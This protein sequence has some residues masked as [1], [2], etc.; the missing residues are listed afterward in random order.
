MQGLATNQV[1]FGAAYVQ[2]AIS[3]VK[4]KNE[5][6][7]NGKQVSIWDDYWLEGYRTLFN[8]TQ[9]QNLHVVNDLLDPDREG[10]NHKLLSQAFPCQIADKISNIECF[11]EAQSQH[12]KK[13]LKG[14]WLA[15]I[16]N[17][18]K[19]F[20][21]MELNHLT[22]QAVDISI[23]DVICATQE[24]QQGKFELM[25]M[26]M[27]RIWC[28]R[29]CKAYGQGDLGNSGVAGLGFVV[30]SHSGSVLVAGSKRVNF[31]T[32]VVEPE[33]KAIL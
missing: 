27:W 7:A 21:S 28:V 18:V 23:E 4:G 19:I 30:R 17:K 8:H 29:N 13:W 2:R 5:I 32:L 24:R 25:P 15:N 22:N 14:I 20:A 6:L 12:E 26:L 31:V 16:P 1:L 10:W 9:N 3:Y 11:Q 33:T